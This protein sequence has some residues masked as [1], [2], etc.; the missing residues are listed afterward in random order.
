MV[1]VEVP[2]NEKI[3]AGKVLDLLFAEKENGR[4]RG[5][6]RRIFQSNVKL[7]LVKVRIKQRSGEFRKE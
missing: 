7:H 5:G 1:T 2:Q 3:S 4:V 6:K